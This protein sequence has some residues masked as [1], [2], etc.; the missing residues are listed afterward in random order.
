MNLTLVFY[1]ISFA[2][3][4]S[5]IILSRIKRSS[6][7][8]SK[9]DYDKNSLRILWITIIISINAGSILARFPFGSIEF[10]PYQQLIALILIII[11]II[12]RWIAILKLKDSFTVDVN[13][14]E[15]QVI[16]TDGLYKK[17]RHPAYLGSLISFLGLSLV[18]INIYSFLIVI[19]PITIAFL[20]RI[21]IEENVLSQGLGEGYIKYSR[22]TKKLIP[23]IY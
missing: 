4:V 11:G 13:V 20:H 12:I 19:I 22:R 16:V 5:E 3:V 7:G 6:V 17:I 10:F 8:S 15:N 9:S 23:F 18:F 2:W 14:K 21:K 1:I